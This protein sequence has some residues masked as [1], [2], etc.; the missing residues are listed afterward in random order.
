MSMIIPRT[1][2][3]PTMPAVEVPASIPGQAGAASPFFGSF[4]DGVKW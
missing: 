1:I 2:A 3:A 4:P